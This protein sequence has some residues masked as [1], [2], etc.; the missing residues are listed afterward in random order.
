M[1]ILNLT[2]NLDDELLARARELAAARKMTVEQMIE[3]LLQ[4]VAQPPLKP[5]ELPPRTRQ[6]LGIIPPQTDEEDQ[7]ALDEYRT[8]KYAG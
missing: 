2:L 7:R 8:M 1:T 3:R 6:L 5:E 4:V